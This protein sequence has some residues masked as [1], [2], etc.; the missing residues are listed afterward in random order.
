MTSWN[1]LRK[2]AHLAAIWD[3]S[4]IPK[5]TMLAKV[6]ISEAKYRNFKP[7]ID[8]ETLADPEFIPDGILLDLFANEE[9]EYLL[10]L[11]T[12]IVYIMA[13]G[14][15]QSQAKNAEDIKAIIGA[16]I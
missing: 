11:E 3:G 10:D 8:E 2:R 15:A 9:E 1:K 4:S 16:C 5:V 12:D 6:A 7:V 14:C 13:R